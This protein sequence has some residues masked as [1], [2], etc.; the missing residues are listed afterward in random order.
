MKSTI[1]T[2]LTFIIILFFSTLSHAQFGFKAGVNIPNVTVDS[3]T[4]TQPEV[5]DKIGFNFGAFISIREYETFSIRS[6]LTFERKNIE[7]K[8]FAT[9]SGASAEMSVDYLIYSVTG[10]Y[11]FMEYNKTSP[12]LL[13]S[14][15]LNFYLG[16]DYTSS[17]Q[18]SQSQQ[19][20]ISDKMRKIG[21]GLSIGA[22]IEFMREKNVIP[23]IEVQFSPD[24]FNGYDSEII[25]FK[26]NSIEAMIGIRFDNSLKVFI[27]K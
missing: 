21:F 2:L 12:Y 4:F 8:R 9:T 16:N 10:K 24:F 14:P 22:G 7:G 19:D 15:R 11:T 26:S 6:G 25:S 17:P 23:F 20:I 5:K 18:L 3:R 27:G 13:F 1:K